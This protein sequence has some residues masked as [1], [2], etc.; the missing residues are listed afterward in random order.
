MRQ[1]YCHLLFSIEKNYPLLFIRDT[2]PPGRGESF[3]TDIR[4]K[5]ELTI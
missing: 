2:P 4:K 1:T 5:M 3:K